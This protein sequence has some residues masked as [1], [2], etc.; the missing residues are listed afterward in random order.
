[1]KIPVQAGGVTPL[2]KAFE[3]MYLGT[4]GTAFQLRQVS[5]QD[6]NAPS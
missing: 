6:E 3:T 2:L 1:M 5:G 4:A